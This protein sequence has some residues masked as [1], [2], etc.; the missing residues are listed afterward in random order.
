MTDVR[1]LVISR[2]G[3][4]GNG[5]ANASGAPLYVAFTLAGERVRVG[6]SG[7]RWR[8]IDVLSAS[9]DR[10]APVC[11]HFGTC[12]GC[13]L[14]HMAPVVYQ[15]WKRD[16]V[17]AAFAARGIEPVVG[18]LVSP[19]GKRRRAVF[20][21]QRADA[22]VTLGFHEAAS[23]NLIDLA[24]CPVLDNRIVAALPGLRDLV[25]PLMARRG[26]SRLTVTLTRA[27][28]DVALEGIER[29]LTPDVR[30]RVAARAAAL[31][32]A[33]LSI[34]SDPVYQAL[35]PFMRFGTADVVI[36]PGAFVQAVE[37]AETRIASLLVAE[38]GKAKAV[39]DLFS[40]IGAFTFALAAKAKVSAFDSDA[41]AIAALAAGV[42]TAT[43]IKPVVARVRDLLR[44]PLSAMEL[45]DFDAVVFDPPRAGAE[46]QAKMLAKSK[47]KTVLA[48][49]C[50][51]ATL[52]RD[53][54]ILIDGS[55]RLVAVT[56]ID[57]FH[58][59]PHVEAVAVFRR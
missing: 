20:T 9:P 25:E 5:V 53:A 11:R 59:T 42:K 51:P 55:Y 14:Q 56:P 38:L 27:G 36:P 32:L 30:T 58:Y 4:Q 7:D 17:I 45:N 40:G 48:V 6:T 29:Q 16:Q 1:E 12:G 24:E 50:N 21:A 37:D 35:P 43:G 8:L 34:A 3:A 52:A 13:A 2:V 39:A 46:A 33:R 22:G 44:E 28:L 15:A 10:V 41:I 26:E 18:V 19:H 54:R 47:V 31:N 49:S 57:Q 23:H